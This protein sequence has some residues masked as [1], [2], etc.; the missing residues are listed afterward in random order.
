[1]KQTFSDSGR[2]AA[3]L[4]VPFASTIVL[5]PFAILLC[6]ATPAFDDF[7]KA[8]GVSSLGQITDPFAAAWWN[9]QHWTARWFTAF[10]QSALMGRMNLASAQ[11]AWLLAGVMGFDLAA[12][13]IFFRAVMG[14]SRHSSLLMAIVFYAAWAANTDSPG[15]SIYFAT[16]AIE[17]QLSL[18]TLLCAVSLL[19]HERP[20]HWGRTLL[21]VI[22]AFLIPAQHE[23]A[24]G[25]LCAA[26]AAGLLTARYLKTPYLWWTITLIIASASLLMVVASPGVHER[27][28]HRS[29]I[30]GFVAWNFAQAPIC[31]YHAVLSGAEWIINPT[32]LLAAICLPGLIR[33][34]A[35]REPPRWLACLCGLGMAT[36]VILYALV[37]LASGDTAPG[38][39]AGWFQ[40]MFWLLQICAVLIAFPELRRNKGFL[41]PVACCLFA[42]TLVMTP[43]FRKAVADIAAPARQWHAAITDQLRRGVPGGNFTGLPPKPELFLEPGTASPR[44]SAWVGSCLASYERAREPVK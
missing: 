36:L 42:I 39:V 2:D 9:Y 19:C 5:I 43:N 23:I 38:R 40:W 27:I 24:G 21:L 31:L 17:Y 35:S 8:S 30:G 6:C 4:L 15:E 14:I 26:L 18:G 44:N 28:V 41:R 32:V 7:C 10:L 12:L 29:I 13:W 34:D 11:Y 22:L 20:L 1:M 37:E 16:V 25:F 3:R 33:F